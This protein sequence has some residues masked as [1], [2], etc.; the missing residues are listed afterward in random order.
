SPDR[1]SAAV[2]PV[3]TGG[4]LAARRIH[5]GKANKP[6]LNGA[7]HR[8]IRVGDSRSAHCRAAC[9]CSIWFD[10][11]PAAAAPADRCAQ[12]A[13]NQPATAA[14]LLRTRRAAAP[15]AAGTN[16]PAAVES[17][18]GRHD[19]DATTA[20]TAG[21]RVGTAISAGRDHRGATAGIAAGSRFTA[22][23]SAAGQYGAATKR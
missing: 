8:F 20:A 12:H 21:R 15:A 14:I 7:S 4:A 5:A 1:P 11:R 9:L 19:P 3:L 16:E 13:A 6:D 17:P 2:I 18:R 22:Q 23:R 10:L